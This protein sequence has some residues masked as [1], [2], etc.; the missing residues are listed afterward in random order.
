MATSRRSA[1]L[2]D[3]RV[4]VVCD[5]RDDVRYC[6]ELQGDL[7]RLSVAALKGHVEQ[8]TGVGE[9]QQILHFE[10]RLLLD[11]ESVSDVGLYNH[12][13]L[14]LSKADPPLLPAPYGRNEIVYLSPKASPARTRC[15]AVRQRARAACPD[16]EPRTDCVGRVRQLEAELY[17]LVGAL[18]GAEDADG[19]LH[20][21]GSD[22]EAVIVVESSAD[23]ENTNTGYR[24]VL[25]RTA[26]PPLPSRD[27]AGRVRAMTEELHYVRDVAGCRS[28]SSLIERQRRMTQ[29]PRSQ[30][31]ELVRLIQDL[32]ARNDVLR[33]ENCNARSSLARTRSSHS[34]M[35]V[36]ESEGWGK[37]R[38]GGVGG[39]RR[40]T[41][42]GGLKP[43]RMKRTVLLQ[44]WKPPMPTAASPE[45]LRELGVRPSTPGMSLSKRDVH[46]EA[47]WGQKSTATSSKVW[48]SDEDKLTPAGFLADVYTEAM[49][50]GMEKTKL[51]AFKKAMFKPSETQGGHGMHGTEFVNDF[52]VR[53]IPSNT[54]Q[55]RVRFRARELSGWTVD[56]WNGKFEALK[57]VFTFDNPRFPFFLYNRINDRVIVQGTHYPIEVVMEG[58]TCTTYFTTTYVQGVSE[59]DFQISGFLDRERELMNRP[60]WTPVV[61]AAGADGR[62]TFDFQAPARV[63][64]SDVNTALALG[65]FLARLTND[66]ISV[67]HDGKPAVE[68]KQELN[69]WYRAMDVVNCLVELA[70][71]VGEY[72]AWVKVNVGI[73]TVR[74]VDSAAGRYMMYELDALLRDH[75]HY[76]ASVWSRKLGTL[77]ADRPLAEEETGHLADQDAPPRSFFKKNPLGKGVGPIRKVTYDLP[78]NVGERL[79]QVGWGGDGRAQVDSR[80]RSRSVLDAADM[81]RARPPAETQPPDLLAKLQSTIQ[82]DERMRHAPRME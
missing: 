47:W 19:R 79:R 24:G 60:D 52:A 21:D 40:T 71:S 81:P 51:E 7:R 62:K 25:E 43:K 1:R 31:M 78:K 26:A 46:P 50:V 82:A 73:V 54:H 44:C 65:S 20:E 30:R 5:W 8:C 17:D 36:H 29:Q 77:S 37:R 6:V 76:L 68:V 66:W 33:Q 80:K 16:Q 12:A 39:E 61:R 32:E 70:E 15:A 3:L 42:A 67:T 27:D 4:F 18:D 9:G 11:D 48:H 34:P 14:V 2:S 59:L 22:A 64:V 74:I 28:S 58:N 41:F 63:D 45:R 10:G 57:K 72:P 23:F 13:T 38:G 49:A 75:E 35:C 56:K 55:F 53:H 69:S